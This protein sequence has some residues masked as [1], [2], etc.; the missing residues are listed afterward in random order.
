MNELLFTTI[1]TTTEKTA[2]KGKFYYLI[3]MINSHKFYN[4]MHNI[5]LLVIF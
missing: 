1:T 2:I 3:V 5:M 4:E